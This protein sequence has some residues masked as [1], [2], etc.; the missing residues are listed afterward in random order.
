MY[1]NNNMLLGLLILF[2]VG[3]FHVV[4]F[5]IARKR[6]RDRAR[7]SYIRLVKDSVFNSPF[8]KKQAN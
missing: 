7:E 2:S 4:V 6:K 5:L 3:V 1:P 8:V